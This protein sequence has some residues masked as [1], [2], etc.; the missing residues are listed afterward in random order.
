MGESSTSTI[1]PGCSLQPMLEDRVRL[2]WAARAFL[3][4]VTVPTNKVDTKST[5]YANARE[6]FDRS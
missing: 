2:H 4:L 5:Q 1:I 3:Y 6:W